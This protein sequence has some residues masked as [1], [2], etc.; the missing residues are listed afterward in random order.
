VTLS[1]VS[2]L[3]GWV[4][5]LGDVPDAAFA[6]GLVGDGVVI[7]PLQSTLHA[8][9][10]GRIVGVHRAGHAV[11]VRAENG[12]ELLIHVGIETV[13]LGGA[14][15]APQVAAGDT[16]AAGDVLLRFD[17]D[18][19][20]SGAPSL[21]TPVL[22]M[23]GQAFRVAKRA[24]P[25]RIAVGDWLMDIEAAAV[26]GPAPA[27]GGDWIEQAAVIPPGH[28]LHAR[29]AAAI[30]A[31]LRGLDAVVEIATTA[32]TAPATSAV[33]LMTLGLSAG[34][35]ATLR[36]RG[37][38]ARQ[39]LARL[40]ALIE[41]DFG[42]VEPSAPAPAS[43]AGGVTAVPGLAIGT[44]RRLTSVHYD[45]PARGMGVAAETAALDAALAQVRDG[46]RR[47]AASGVAAQRGIA[48]A[49]LALLDDPRSHPAA[50]R[51]IEAGAS[52]GAAWIAALAPDIAALRGLDD[53]RLAGRAD[54]LLDLQRQVVAATLGSDA[55]PPSLPPETIL[56]AAD[57]LP[58]ELMALDPASLAGIAL[59]GGGPTSHV[60]IIAAA[61]GLPM[62][63]ALGEPALALPDATRAVLDA[64]GGTLHPADAATERAALDRVA[65][66][67]AARQ[68]AHAASA[69]ACR[70]ADGTRIEV[71]ANLGS[72]EDAAVAVAAGAEGCGLLRTELLFLDRDEAPDEAEQL[73]LYQAIADRLAGRPLIIR[74]LDIGGD[75]PV[76]YLDLPAEENPA[77]GLR[78]IR[79]GLA[80]P[81]LLD[82]Q[83]RA[84]LAVAPAVQ[85]RILL[86]MIASLDELQAVRARVKVLARA[87]GR[88]EPVSV[89]VMIETPAAAIAA[90]LLAP[91]ADFFAI[92]TNDLAQYTLAMDRGNAGV[93]AQ[94]DALHPAVLRLIGQAARAAAA[95]GR[96]VGVC[97]GL[98]SDPVAAP[99][100]IGLGVEELSAVPGVIPELKA[101]VRTL[102]RARC[103]ALA[104]AA[105]N[106]PSAAAVR[107]L[108][109]G[110]GA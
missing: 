64:H 6:Q 47:Q 50:I 59:A 52:A 30:V 99:I 11:T 54:D 104:A 70:M 23:E 84:I 13:A 79:V 72:A 34:D 78:G 28:G 67:Q 102:D 8:P 93:A 89:G 2:P 55:P 101:R 36:A 37:P 76:R 73:A 97:G 45:P 20:A 4:G 98:A 71:F 58:S 75:K 85:A 88:T 41:R 29:P 17:P 10:A 90:D 21:A 49:H 69:E 44:V 74:T 35:A 100:L 3:A 32:A 87:M 48:E 24:G 109:A 26:D 63:V 95:H 12:A 51:A 22:L 103:E 25:A 18:R 53:P 77:L 5:A 33:A 38:A 15:F 106:Q 91:A 61:R 83:L 66:R 81:A 19:L 7:E 46:L 14:G 65:A 62:A 60:A 110:W 39:A 16:V 86:P 31:A 108:A 56:V 82:E 43:P 105:L 96:P 94:V 80:H 1:L 68:A 107:A 9:C 42:M 40:T 57:L 92:G 27:D